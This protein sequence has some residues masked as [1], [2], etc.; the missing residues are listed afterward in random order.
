MNQ[1]EAYLAFRCLTRDISYWEMFSAK[2]AFCY[3]VKTLEN[4]LQQHEEGVF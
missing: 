1:I 3:L 4:N 2:E